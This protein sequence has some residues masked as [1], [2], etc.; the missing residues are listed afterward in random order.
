MLSINFSNR[1]THDKRVKILWET[2]LLL[3]YHVKIHQHI[4]NT[5][6]HCII[7]KNTTYS[8]FW[9]I[10]WA[11]F[12]QRCFKF[13]PCKK[14]FAGWI[15]LPETESKFRGGVFH[16]GLD[17]SILGP[18]VSTWSAKSTRMQTFCKARKGTHNWDGAAHSLL[19]NRC[20]DRRE[21]I[22]I[23]W[24]FR[25]YKRTPISHN[26]FCH[27]WTWIE[28]G[29]EREKMIWKTTYEERIGDW[30]GQGHRQHSIRG[31]WGCRC[32]LVVIRCSCWPLGQP[33]RRRLQG[34]RRWWW[35]RTLCDFLNEDCGLEKLEGR[36]WFVTW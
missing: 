17:R 5:Q 27:E 15:G 12:W 25:S 21:I 18:T 22:H 4:L 19:P 28:V 11:H 3:C 2:F 29:I 26:L 7:S 14:V 23:L 1:H 16:Q 10:S 31:C 6:Q 30:R 20:A 13:P 34:A 36:F 9:F 32:R 8:I 33:W 24:H 35:R